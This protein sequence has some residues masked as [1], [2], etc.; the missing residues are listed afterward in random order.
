LRA[1]SLIRSSVIVSVTATPYRPAGPV[2]TGIL[3]T[4]LSDA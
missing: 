3:S 1:K 4:P 2:R